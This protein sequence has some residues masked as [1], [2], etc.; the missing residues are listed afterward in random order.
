M[1]AA[2]SSSAEAGKSVAADK[3]QEEV[4]DRLQQVKAGEDHEMLQSEEAP[5]TTT[6]TANASS[7]MKQDT[8]V[9]VPS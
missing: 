3:E 7:S 4:Q 1:L 6:K 8:S 9:V 2:N 5:A